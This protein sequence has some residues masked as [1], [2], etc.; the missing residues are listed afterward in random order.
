MYRSA[1]RELLMA[2]GRGM[3][4]RAWVPGTRSERR[5]GLLGRTGLP[6]G[7]ALL[8]EHAR[9]VHTFGMRFAI[10]AVLLDEGLTVVAVRRL[11]PNRL[12]LPRPGIRHVLECSAGVDVR[13]GDRLVG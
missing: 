10:D 6:P 2:N 8:L 12:L 4:L 13:E 1:V 9:S 3:E 7:R 5:R 11:V